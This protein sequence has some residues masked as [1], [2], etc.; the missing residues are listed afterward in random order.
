[1]LKKTECFYPLGKIIVFVCYSYIY[2]SYAMYKNNILC[3]QLYLNEKKNMKQ[4]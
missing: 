3:V 4:V 2:A 1:M